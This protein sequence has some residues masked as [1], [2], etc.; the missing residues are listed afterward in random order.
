MA[1][2]VRETQR[3]CRRGVRTG[4]VPAASGGGRP[5]AGTMYGR[6]AGPPPSGRV[7]E[8]AGGNGPAVAYAGREFMANE[9]NLKPIRDHT[10]AQ[11]L[12]R[13]GGKRS[14]QARRRKKEFRDVFSAI[15]PME[16]SDA[17]GEEVG[18]D[19]KRQPGGLTAAQAMA[20]A[21]VVKAIRG[22]TKAF[23]LSQGICEQ[24]QS[25]SGE[26]DAGPLQVDIRVVE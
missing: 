16:I 18:L 19:F 15:L 20:M 12:G 8:R 26:A 25:E 1:G 22:D 11:E 21:Q 3:A 5:P 14:G 9:E 17:L 6:R 7:R 23:A 24:T 2:F 13:R 4:I 10:R